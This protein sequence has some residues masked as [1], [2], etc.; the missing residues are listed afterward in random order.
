MKKILNEWREYLKEGIDDTVLANQIVNLSKVVKKGD[1]TSIAQADEIEKVIK[2]FM[3][4]GKPE[5]F[6]KR[7][8]LKL[9]DLA[10]LVSQGNYNEKQVRDMRVQFDR[11]IKSMPQ[12]KN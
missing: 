3:T 5:E 4:Y 10:K 2:Q 12:G 11:I 9:I 6:K 7:T 1:A 8:Y